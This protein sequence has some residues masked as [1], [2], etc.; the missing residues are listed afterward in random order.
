MALL[1]L[2]FP[3]PISEFLPFANNEHNKQNMKK[4]KLTSSFVPL[5]LFE[6]QTPNQNKHMCTLHSEHALCF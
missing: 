3:F 5:S 1:A 2:Q 6:H 4:K